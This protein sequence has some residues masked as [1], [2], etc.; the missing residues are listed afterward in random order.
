[1]LT[2]KQ[3]IKMLVWSS[4]VFLAIFAFAYIY[5]VTHMES[6]VPEEAH[7]YEQPLRKDREEIVSEVSNPDEQSILPSTVITMR[8]LDQHSNVISQEPV[9][10]SSLLGLN[11]VEI[12]KVFDRCKVVQFDPREVVIE[13][14][15]YIEPKPLE[16]KLGIEEGEIGII[17]EGEKPIFSS[18]GLSTKEF[19]KHTNLLFVNEMIHITPTE[20][21]HL[22]KDP[23]YIEYILQALS[24]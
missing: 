9:E 12:E 5:T 22:E 21:Q 24:E 19:S 8:I 10:S 1:M 14:T 13:K 2:K 18:L 20:K 3:Y 16:Y 7:G 4:V 17:T 6:I 23:N 11:K 15:E